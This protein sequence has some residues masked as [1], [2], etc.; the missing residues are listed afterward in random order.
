[1]WP[2]LDSS[3]SSSKTKMHQGL[4]PVSIAR[5]W[6]GDFADPTDQGPWRAWVSHAFGCVCKR[7][8]WL[9]R[10]T[11][12]KQQPMGWVPNW[13]KER[14]RK[15]STGVPFALPPRVTEMRAICCHVELPTARVTMPFTSQQTV[16]SKPNMCK[17]KLLVSKVFLI[18]YW[19]LRQE[20]VQMLM[21]FCLASPS[22]TRGLLKPACHV[23]FL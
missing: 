15:P 8:R 16:P 7:I 20:N 21:P 11:M 19:W 10:L 5:C 9:G 6:D 14:R 23:F 4:Y 3:T 1:L 18:V 12:N 17:G 13:A 2:E 22:G